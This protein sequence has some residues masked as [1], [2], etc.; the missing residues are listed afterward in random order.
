MPR[1]QRR[2]HAVRS[3]YSGPSRAGDSR[4]D[5]RNLPSP[6]KMGVCAVDGSVAPVAWPTAASR[7][8]ACIW[9]ARRLRRTSALSYPQKLSTWL[10]TCLPTA[11][12]A[13]SDVQYAGAANCR[14][15]YF[16][17]TPNAEVPMLGALPVEALT[18]LSEEPKIAVHRGF[19]PFS[20]PRKM[21]VTC[22]T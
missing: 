8:L 7:I 13:L 20:R 16:R 6:E 11:N 12:D 4:R 2:D 19:T 22:F 3:P 21:A 18:M 10:S 5:P 17:A 1:P 9:M 14:R 15:S